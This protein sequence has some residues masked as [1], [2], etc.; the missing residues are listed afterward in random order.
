MKCIIEN[1]D[2]PALD[3][4]KLTDILDVM[5]QL[6]STIKRWVWSLELTGGFEKLQYIPLFYQI[7]E[8]IQSTF[9]NQETI[10][11]VKIVLIVGTLKNWMLR[12]VMP[13]ETTIL[14]SYYCTHTLEDFFTFMAVKF[15]NPSVNTTAINLIVYAPKI[16]KTWHS[17]LYTV[18]VYRKLKGFLTSKSLYLYV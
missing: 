14:C 15:A 4:E 12:M 6:L 18:F 2:T 13:A 10:L 11:I 3:V 1:K 9:H 16:K 17:G 7:Y 5:I 8:P